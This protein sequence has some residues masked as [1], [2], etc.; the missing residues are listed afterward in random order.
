MAKVEVIAT[1][2]IVAQGLTDCPSSPLVWLV[3]AVRLRIRHANE[4][5][6]PVD[7]QK[8]CLIVLMGM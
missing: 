8:D 7:R 5:I 2:H 3:A 1:S 6:G 4:M